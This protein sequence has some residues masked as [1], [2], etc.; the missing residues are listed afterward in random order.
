MNEPLA[1]YIAGP[2]IGLLVPALLMLREKQFGISSSYRY[3]ASLINARLDYLNYKRKNDLWQVQFAL[4][5]LIAGFLYSGFF[6]PFLD[7]VV[8][9]KS[10]GE[11]IGVYD[12]KNS[13]QFF[14]GGVLIG[15][16]SRYANGCTAGHC[17]MGMSQ[18]SLASIV[19]TICF[20]MGGLLGS[21]LLVPYLF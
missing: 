18:F 9:L 5:I 17:I 10:N 8:D 1:W 20:F 16:G 15:F 21:Y 6:T 13:P 19:T 3:W 12:W 11:L 2:L 4:G 7:S 14:M